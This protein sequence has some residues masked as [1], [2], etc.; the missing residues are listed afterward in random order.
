[1]RT[2]RVR[3]C[4][5]LSTLHGARHQLLGYEDW[6]VIDPT[7]LPGDAE[8]NVIFVKPRVT[9]N[10]E[11]PCTALSLLFTHCLGNQ[12]RVQHLAWRNPRTSKSGM[13]IS[14]NSEAT[15]GSMQQKQQ[16]AELVP[17]ELLGNIFHSKR[18]CEFSIANI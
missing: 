3:A 7:S 17:W 2:A 12:G 11:A 4:R 16:L 14:E 8:L 13:F 15:T 6:E 18:L 9:G 5:V 1:M 10:N